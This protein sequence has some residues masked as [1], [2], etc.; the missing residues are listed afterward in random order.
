[1]NL[2]DIITTS[3]FA[4]TAPTQRKVC[5]AKKK[6]RSFKGLHVLKLAPSHPWAKNWQQSYMSDLQTRFPGGQGLAELLQQIAGQIPAPILCCYEKN[7]DQCHRHLL[8]EYIATHLHISV[9]E[10]NRI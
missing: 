3:Y 7:P 4:S 2:Q 9:G 1:M 6:P 10:W 8:A 5:I